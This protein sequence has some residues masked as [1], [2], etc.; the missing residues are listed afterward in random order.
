MKD[1]TL[2]LAGHKILILDGPY[3]IDGKPSEDAK[4]F[5]ASILDSL[6]NIR[7]F[8]CD[9][10]LAKFNSVWRDEDELELDNQPSVLA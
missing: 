4:Q 10:L 7:R 2:R 8:A 1:C 5:A 6:E 3:V 9:K